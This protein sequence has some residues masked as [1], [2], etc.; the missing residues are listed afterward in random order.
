MKLMIR[1]IRDAQGLTGEELAERAG[2][3]RSYLTEIE[4]GTKTPNTR[5]LESIA[6]ALG[7][8]PE[9]LMEKPESTAPLGKVIRGFCSLPEGRQKIVIDLID[10]LRADDQQDS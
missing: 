1:E 9:D 4:K 8:W 7:V 5:R 6:K 10:S 3:S 2:I